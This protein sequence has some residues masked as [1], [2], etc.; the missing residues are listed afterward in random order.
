M[1]HCQTKKCEFNPG[2]GQTVGTAE[3]PTGE[4]LSECEPYPDISSVSRGG[5]VRL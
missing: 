4:D 5:S 2:A 1:K 3:L